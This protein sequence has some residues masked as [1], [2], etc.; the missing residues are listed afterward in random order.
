MAGF[1]LRLDSNAIDRVVEDSTDAALEAAAR[2]TANRAR[3]NLSAAGRNNTGRLAQSI[4]A[5]R[6][7]PFEWTVGSFLEYAIYQE[8]GVRGPIYPKRA[9]VL[10]FKPKG[11]SSFVFA[12]YTKGFAGVHYLRDAYNALTEADFQP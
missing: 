4:Q 9:K 7:G 8:E 6:A 5:R 1:Y 10:R 3:I 11:A 12:R 2:T